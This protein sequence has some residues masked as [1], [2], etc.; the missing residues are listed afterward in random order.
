MSV[1][2]VQISTDRTVF[3]SDA[4][5]D[6]VQRQ[7]RYGEILDAM[8]P[9]SRLTL[10]VYTGYDDVSPIVR[11]NVHF[12]PVRGRRF[13]LWL[14]LIRTVLRLHRQR[15]ID[16]ITP[17]AVF[18]K[19][20]I[21]LL[22]A[23]RTR[24]RL[25][26]QAHIDIFHPQ[27]IRERLGTGIRARR[28]YRLSLLALRWSYAVRVVGQ[29]TRDEIERRGLNRRV[30]V[31]PVPISLPAPD[32]PANDKAGVGPVVLFVG[33]LVEQKNL[34]RWLRVAQQVHEARPD[35]RF[36]I[37]G[38]GPLR[39]DLIQTA[40]SLGLSE[41]V[42]FT[43]AAPYTQLAQHYTGA[44][45]FLLTSHYEGFGRVIAEAALFAVPSV[46]THITGVEDIIADGETGY[47]VHPED[48]A[49]L[50][51]AVLTLLNH[52][53]LREQLGANARKRVLALFDAEAL[54]QQWMAFLVD[55]ARE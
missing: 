44:S 51:Q 41:Q 27:A 10:L 39:D 36:V 9:G 38:D 14:N 16:V 54:A 17:Q 6:T 19:P 8:R 18:D 47:L 53:P 46:A 37:V 2:I 20:L 45:V 22:L 26:T 13:D 30:A 24:A 33:R 55:C 3:Q 25:A 21:I 11:G 52:A 32:D 15:R 5:S 23:L 48:D 28:R 31:I 40:Q 1:H 42:H 7:L 50:A 43:G 49:G 35:A 34:R 12:I 4:A 29:R